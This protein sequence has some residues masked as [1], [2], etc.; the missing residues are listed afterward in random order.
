MGEFL[1]Y[2]SLEQAVRDAASE[3]L[4]NPEI[5]IVEQSRLR[6]E[7]L[8]H[9]EETRIKVKLAKLEEQRQG[10]L[11]LYQMGEIQDDYLETEVTKIRTEVSFLEGGLRSDGEDVEESDIRNIAQACK[12]I[13]A[14][15]GGSPTK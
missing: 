6:E 2:I 9:Q 10:L 12:R 14:N 7:S 3:G 1:G 15:S 13:R 8:G 5:I 11:K 4:A